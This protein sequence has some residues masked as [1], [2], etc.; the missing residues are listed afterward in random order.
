MIPAV[1]AG[2]VVHPNNLPLISFPRKRC[3]SEPY[4]AFLRWDEINT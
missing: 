2:A 3:R 4:G 1:V